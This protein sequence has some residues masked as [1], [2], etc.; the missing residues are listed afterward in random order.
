MITKKRLRAFLKEDW[1]GVLA[2]W[3]AFCLYMISEPLVLKVL[4][5][6][7]LLIV[8]A[9]VG[10]SFYQQREFWKMDDL[11]LKLLKHDIEVILP[12]PTIPEER[13]VQI[14]KDIA[15]IR[16]EMDE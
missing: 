13:K 16:K 14:R 2:V 3:M 6:I 10:I 1:I 9:M 7:A 11:T 4:T 15:R 8:S 12:D 5:L